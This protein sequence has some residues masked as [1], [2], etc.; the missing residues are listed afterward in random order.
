MKRIGRVRAV[1]RIGG[2]GVAA[3]GVCLLVG[4]G[5]QAQDEPEPLDPR[6][7][8]PAPTPTVS[9]QPDVPDCTPGPRRS[10]PPVPVP[11]SPPSTLTPYPQVDCAGSS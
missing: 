9:V 2:L 5:V 6:T 7:V 11:S 10:A 8:G 4:C 3:L 1:G